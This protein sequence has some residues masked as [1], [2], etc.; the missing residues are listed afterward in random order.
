PWG[1]AY[2]IFVSVPEGSFYPQCVGTCRIDRPQQELA[3]QLEAE[4]KL[5]VIVREASG[6]AVGGAMVFLT[7]V[8]AEDVDAS[9]VSAEPGV[10]D[11]DGRA[12]FGA[13]GP[14]AY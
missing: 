8:F 9:S 5:T 2:P 14:G 10:T 12:D 6:E 4:G 13:L 7:Q 3:L 1:R 11:A